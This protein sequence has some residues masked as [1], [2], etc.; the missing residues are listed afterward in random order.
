MVKDFRTESSYSM[1]ANFFEG[2][3]APFF[4]EKLTALSDFRNLTFLH[5]C[6]TGTHFI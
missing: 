4:L 5:G 6:E 1:F 3:V 2:I